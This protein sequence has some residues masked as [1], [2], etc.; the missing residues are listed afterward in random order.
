MRRFTK[1]I[2][3]LPIALAVGLSLFIGSQAKRT[4]AGED[5]GD[6]LNY[7]FAVWLGS[8]VYKVSDADKRLVVLR[9]PLGYTLRDAKITVFLYTT[10][11]DS[12][13]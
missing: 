6:L 2:K 13:Y 10:G 1:E 9:V 8:G 12:S 5:E 11:L 7:S 4:F 3:W